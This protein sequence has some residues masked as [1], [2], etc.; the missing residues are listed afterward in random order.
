MKGLIRIVPTHVLQCQRGYGIKQF[1]ELVENPHKIMLL[2]G[3]CSVATEA[4]GEA[5][6]Y[7]NL[8]QVSRAYPNHR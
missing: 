2:G 5:S 4:T 6:H 7:W 8:V 1:V 3:G